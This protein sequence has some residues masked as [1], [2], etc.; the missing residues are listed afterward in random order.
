MKVMKRRKMIIARRMVGRKH[1]QLPNVKQKKKKTKPWLPLLQCM[2]ERFA[3]CALE[4]TLT[5]ARD[6]PQALVGSVQ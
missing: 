3:L 2:A 1:L 6:M 4:T 5:A